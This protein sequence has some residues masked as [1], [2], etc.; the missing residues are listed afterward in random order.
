MAELPKKRKN[1]KT[2]CPDGWHPSSREIQLQ[3]T[4]RQERYAKRCVGITRFVYYRMVA[5]DQAGRDHKL[6]LTPY[7]LEKEFNA[8]KKINKSLKFVTQVS[9]FVAQG[10]CRNYRNAYYRWR[11]KEL[12]AR[13]PTFHKKKRTGT[14]SFLAASGI[15]TIKYDGHKPHQ[16][17]IHR[18]RQN[19]KTPAGRHHPL[20]SNHQ[21]TKRPLVRQPRILGTHS[22][23][24]ADEKLNQQAERMS[25]INTPSR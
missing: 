12:D 17:A 2:S 4:V 1:Q 7:E 6:W 9:K 25:G 16:A 20:R 23:A 15:V 5:N 22:T 24:A 14:G 13:K 10:A 11:N 3:L 19:D 18:Q 21:E 8:A